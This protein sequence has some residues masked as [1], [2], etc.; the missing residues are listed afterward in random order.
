MSVVVY[1]SDGQSTL[2]TKGAPEL[3]EKL[4]AKG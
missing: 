4:F 2:L 1:E 3:M